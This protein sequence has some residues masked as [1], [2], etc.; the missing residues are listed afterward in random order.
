M[1]SRLA[2]FEARSVQ[3]KLTGDCRRIENSKLALASLPILKINEQNPKFDIED[4]ASIRIMGQKNRN[5]LA[6]SVLVNLRS[7]TRPLT[8]SQK[9]QGPA[10]PS[11]S[12]SSLQ[13][14]L[15]GSLNCL[16]FQGA[17][18]HAGAL[19]LEMDSAHLA[20]WLLTNIRGQGCIRLTKLGK[21]GECIR[22][23]ICM[24]IIK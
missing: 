3:K 12:K 2:C 13:D 14:L 19:S 9:C 1:S 6:D 24:G 4:D 5:P 10:S 20:M 16:S 17:A 22:H 21:I 11:R 18:I 15:L 8:A 23:L 7:V